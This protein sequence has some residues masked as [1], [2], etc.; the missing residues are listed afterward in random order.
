MFGR[1]IRVW[2]TPPLQRQY[3]ISDFSW[4][5]TWVQLPI[6]RGSPSC[7]DLI[8]GWP[9]KTKRKWIWVV[10]DV[11]WDILIGKSLRFEFKANNNQEEYK[12]LIVRMAL[13]REM[14]TSNLRARNDYQ[15][16]T[17]QLT[18]YYQKKEAC[19]VNYLKSLQGPIK[20]FICLGN[21]RVL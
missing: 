1:T 12:T 14:G 9:I 7:V 2:H 6:Q 5:L 8:N 11:P 21:L 20:H 19:L 18:R 16:V 17:S 3:K 4:L 10:L 15:L 13:A